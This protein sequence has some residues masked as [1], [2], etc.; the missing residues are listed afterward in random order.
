M[1]KRTGERGLTFVE[2]LVALPIAALIIAG[3]GGIFYQL[4]QANASAN[5]NVA[6]YTQVQRVGA[7]ISSAVVQAQVVPDNNYGDTGTTQISIDQDVNVAGT[8]V[9]LTQWTEWDGNTIQT[10]Y[11]IDSMADSTLKI[12]R[13]TVKTDGAVTETGIAAEYLD[14]SI[15]P[16]T[17]LPRTRLEWSS[18]EKNIVRLV[19]TAQVGQQSVVRTYE[20]RPRAT[21]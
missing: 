17:S 8:E 21:L 3:V 12:L 20:T 10:L 14:D 13:R 19:V 9:F 15:D 5:D 16:E 4:M 6:A 7:S 18:D 11:S 2:L 1:H